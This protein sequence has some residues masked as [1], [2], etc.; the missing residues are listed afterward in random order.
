MTPIAAAGECLRDRPSFE[1]FPMSEPYTGAML[2]W[3]PFTPRC[4]TYDP[5]AY[6]RSLPNDAER[7]I[8]FGHLNVPGVVPASETHEM[9]RGRDV[10]F[11][12]DAIREHFGGRALCFNGHYHSTNDGKKVGVGIPGTLARLTFGEQD[13]TPGC[14]LVDLDKGS[15]EFIPY[16]HARKLVTVGPE[17]KLWA[18]KKLKFDA[19]PSTIVRLQPPADCSDSK[20][21]EV[22][23]YLA[24]RVAAV[25]TMPAPKGGVAV[26]TEK[27]EKTPRVSTRGVIEELL[28]APMTADR[29]KVR[30]IVEASMNEAG[31]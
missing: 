20:I 16:P 23:D 6:V 9:P 27:I 30:A 14:L 31:L 18:V 11:P 8:V 22:R 13:N 4:A 5:A 21:D 10:W 28:T 1:M 24:S 17:E 15:A 12:T 29:D 7:V 25:K 19:D 26:V 3:L 2:V